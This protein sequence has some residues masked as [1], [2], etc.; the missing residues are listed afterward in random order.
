MA[1]HNKNVLKGNTMNY[2]AQLKEKNDLFIAAREK[3][4]SPA[5]AKTAMDG[6]FFDRIK[7]IKVKKQKPARESAFRANSIA[8]RFESFQ[9]KNTT[10][11]GAVLLDSFFENEGHMAGGAEGILL[12]AFSQ[13]LKDGNGEHYKNNCLK[14]NVYPVVLVHCFGV[15]N[16]M[17]TRIKKSG[18]LPA[19]TIDVYR[20]AAQAVVKSAL[21]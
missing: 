6:G 11:Q 1:R 4:L 8:F 18:L 13:L 2:L 7:P 15:V 14:Q 12:V 5:Q 20:E 9:K 10:L 3:G 16:G 21:K 17:L 19:D